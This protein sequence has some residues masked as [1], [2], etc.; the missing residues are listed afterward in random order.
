MGSDLQR[1][2]C[3]SGKLTS[4]SLANL[5]IEM[6]CL[7]A[8]MTKNPHLETLSLS[9][10]D[11]LGQGKSSAHSFT[12]SV[13]RF[14][15]CAWIKILFSPLH[16]VAIRRPAHLIALLMN[17]SEASLLLWCEICLWKFLVWWFHSYLRMAPTAT[18]L[19][20]VQIAVNS[21]INRGIKPSDQH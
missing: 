12:S 4:V 21:C 10:I 14:S 15:A 8:I 19:T 11:Y 3:C 1:A 20:S 18:R 9:L 17:Q 2:F 16:A 13:S 5:S 7:N 6:S